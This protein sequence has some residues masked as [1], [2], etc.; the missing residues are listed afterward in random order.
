MSDPKSSKSTSVP[1]RLSESTAQSNQPNHHQNP[2]YHPNAPPQSSLFLSN[3]T[4]WTSEDDLRAVL[5]DLGSRIT[6][7]Q[8]LEHKPNGKSKGMVIIEFV[9]VATAESAK[10][11]LEGKEINGRVVEAHFA[12][13]PPVKSYER[14]PS[15]KA[16]YYAFGIELI[17]G[18]CSCFVVNR[19]GE[20][21][22]GNYS[23]NG[24]QRTEYQQHKRPAYQQEQYPP[25]QQSGQ[26]PQY[27]HQHQHQQR[28]KAETRNSTHCDR[29]AAHDINCPAESE[30]RPSTLSSR[31]D[32]RSRSPPDRRRSHHTSSRRY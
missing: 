25:Y 17:N 16:G 13:S 15:N 22:D 30:S 18:F 9:D 3:L 11:L 29:S 4:W 26:Y 2:Q 32:S 20:Y 14:G 5:G 6:E 27:Q 8:F 21:R 19:G 1:D 10:S 7:L 24:N 12:R 23:N 31:R 28:S